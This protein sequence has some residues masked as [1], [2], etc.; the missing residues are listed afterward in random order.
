MKPLTLI[1]AILVALALSRK[2]QAMVTHEPQQ[3]P[4]TG[5]NS[6]QSDAPAGYMWGWTPGEGWQLRVV[7]Y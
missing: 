1:V 4:G 3:L 7:P 6:P 5:V 2:S